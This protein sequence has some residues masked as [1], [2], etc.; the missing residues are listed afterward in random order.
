M[1]YPNGIPKRVSSN[2]FLEAMPAWSPDGK[3]IVFSTWNA[4]GGGLY[5]A[6]LTG[7]NITIQR[8]TKDTALFQSAVYNLTGD[9]IVFLRT[10]SEKFNESTGPFV[11]GSEDDLC[12]ISDKGGEVK[13]IDHAKGRY[14]PHF[15]KKDSTRIYLNSFGSLISI[16]WDGT[17]E[18][19]LAKITGITVSGLINYK[20]GRPV[21][22]HDCML[23]EQA[24][25][26]EIDITPPSPASL[27][28]MSPN[29]SRALTQIN[30]EV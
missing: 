13:L 1:D 21:P 24:T 25:A 20:N 7:K 27:I 9:K 23:P 19:T 5:K 17:D 18:K 8:L 30:N 4:H 15:V 6:N 29:G 16:K 26:E 3:S 28:N 14:N 10:T 11:D 22:P 2:D 12:W